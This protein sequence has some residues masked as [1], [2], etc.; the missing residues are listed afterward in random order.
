MSVI[1]VEA[2]GGWTLDAVH[3]YMRVVNPTL[4]DG[5]TLRVEIVF[6]AELP[7]TSTGK[8]VKRYAPTDTP[9]SIER[10]VAKVL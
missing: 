5:G 8:V 3:D 10:D 2:S 1:E 6:V 7:H 4:P 9:E